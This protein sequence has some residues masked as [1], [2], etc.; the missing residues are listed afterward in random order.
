MIKLGVTGHRPNRIKGWEQNIREFIRSQ[1]K[2]AK[3]GDEEVVLISG[4]ATGVDQIA[5]E[6]AVAAG[7]ELWCYFP[8][9][10]TLV[11]KEKKLVD[12]A[13]F[14][15]FESDE[16]IGKKWCYLRRDQRIVDDCDRL[17]VVW[18]GIKVGGTYD[19]WKYAYEEGRSMRIFRL[20]HQVM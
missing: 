12:K 2:I 8:Y 13:S 16:Y 18:D 17:L 19:T 3:E 14:V 9:Y 1:I 11:E 15:R 4:M 20:D 5:A 10:H 6:E 7:I